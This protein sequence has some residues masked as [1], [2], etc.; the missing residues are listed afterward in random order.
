M[1][2]VGYDF[3]GSYISVMVN[4]NHRHRNAGRV[5]EIRG[6][7][8]VFVYHNGLLSV[9]VARRDFDN[10]LSAIQSLQEEGS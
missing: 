5:R 10:V 4:A 2:V 1:R 6:V 9:Y 3:D 8:E 7:D